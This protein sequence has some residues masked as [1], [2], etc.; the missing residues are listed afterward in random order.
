MGPGDDGMNQVLLPS[1]ISRALNLNLKQVIGSVREKKKKE[2]QSVRRVYRGI[3]RAE[4]W[5][6][7]ESIQ[8]ENKLAS[9]RY[10]E[11][12]RKGWK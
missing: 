1:P 7:L 4:G 12:G 2:R 6:I 8:G 10:G 3:G 9:L 11:Q 5:V